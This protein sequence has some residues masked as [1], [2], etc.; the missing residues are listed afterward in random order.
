MLPQINSSNIQRFE[1][2]EMPTLTYR[3]TEKR[4]AGLI[5]GR[6][7]LL[8][9]MKNILHTERGDYV[10]YDRDYGVEL[11]QYIGAEFGYIKA[12]I[13]KTVRDALMQDNR[14]LDVQLISIERVRTDSAEVVLQ[15]FDNQGNFEFRSF[16]NV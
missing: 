13:E 1:E 11:R 7:A 8:Q 3:E 6:P 5:D 10:I 9:A 16:L 4:V 2:K 15:I 14:V 12:T